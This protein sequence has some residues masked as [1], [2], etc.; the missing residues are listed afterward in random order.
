[1]DVTPPMTPV[2]RH[3][4]LK[5]PVP[6]YLREDKVIT[7]TVTADMLQVRSLLV[8]LTYEPM[9][10]EYQELNSVPLPGHVLLCTCLAGNNKRRHAWLLTPTMMTIRP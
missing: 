7:L 3:S 9:W 2:A 8:E 10:R 5:L 1:M 6:R 4:S